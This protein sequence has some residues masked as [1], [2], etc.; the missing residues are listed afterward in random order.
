MMPVTPLSMSSS[1]PPGPEKPKYV[2]WECHLIKKK[3]SKDLPACE[4]CV[5]RG[6]E[7]SYMVNT[8]RLALSSVFQAVRHAKDIHSLAFTAVMDTYR[9]PQNVRQGV[10]SYFKSINPWFPV[11]DQGDFEGRLESMFENPTAEACVLVLCM[12]AIVADSPDVPKPKKS[13]KSKSNGNGNE[14]L[15]DNAYHSA[16]ATL[17]LVQSKLQMTRPLL[18]AELLIAM[19]EFSNAMFQQAYMSLLRCVQIT[20]VLNW[21]NGIFWNLDRQPLD[22]KELKLC[23]TLWWSI[24]HLDCLLHL[25]HQDHDQPSPML[26]AGLSLHLMIP[27]PEAF[28]QNLLA[29]MPF[30][31]G[32][33]NQ[34]F[35]DA[36]MGQFDDMMVPEA[37][38]AWSLSTVLQHLANPGSLPPPDNDFLNCIINQT[39]KMLPL[40]GRPSDHN[41]ALG[42]NFIALMKLNQTRLLAGIGPMVGPMVPQSMDY[43]RAAKAIESVVKCAGEQATLIAQNPERLAAGAVA[44]CWAIT[45]Y[46]ASLLLVSHGN[47]GLGYMDW[48]QRVEQLK[49]SLDLISKRWKI[50]GEYSSLVDRAIRTRLGR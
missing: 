9:A 41:A 42:T 6:V 30:L 31:A 29:R 23:S 39:Q 12:S 32:G 15:G 48:L 2:C 11:I 33:Q 34:G 18:Q 4:T 44:P 21:H 8:A 5:K 7:C 10:A 35:W 40:R 19:Y 16:K 25:G 17:T 28:D 46:H 24:V 22:A 49:S 26:T 20:K 14:G 47:G 50:A 38:S 36:N 13:P 27:F 43:T 3:C 37:S 45:M 1:P